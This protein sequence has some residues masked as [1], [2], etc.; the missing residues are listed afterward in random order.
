MGSPISGLF[1]DLVMEDLETECLRKLNFSPIF[2]F[3]YVD[4]VITCVPYDKI[5]EI[6]TV[7]DRKS[8]V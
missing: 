2:Y 6:L 1:A 8:V 5:D 7:L 4:D 3:R